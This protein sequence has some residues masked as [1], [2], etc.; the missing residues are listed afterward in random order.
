MAV[1]RLL[2]PLTMW[3]SRHPLALVAIV[4]AVVVSVI[5][6]VSSD[7]DLTGHGH[8]KGFIN[9]PASNDVQMRRHVHHPGEFRLGRGARVSENENASESG[10][11]STAAL[12]RILILTFKRSRSLARC[13]A[14]LNAAV[15]DGQR[16]VVEI[17]IDRTPDGQ[18][19]NET[20]ETANA[21][22]FKHGTVQ[23]HVQPRHGGVVGQW[24]NSWH[25][26]VDSNSSEIAVFVED[27]I[28]LSPYFARWLRRVHGKYDS[29]PA[30]H[31]YAL[32]AESMRHAV[33]AKAGNLQGPPGQCVFLYPVLGSWG[34]SP[35]VGPWRDF[36]RSGFAC[37]FF[38]ERLIHSFLCF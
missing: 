14:S 3:P 7:R 6:L 5:V 26:P 1:R 28:T 15:Y 20:L 34:F 8:V 10:S 27:D 21:F 17:H 35:K 30:I 32:Q 4:A 23:V 11:G 9:P 12:L 36:I 16:A 31:G 22:V 18:V 33:G 25:V 19:H 38:V 2:V 13:L 37:V 24:L 29:Y